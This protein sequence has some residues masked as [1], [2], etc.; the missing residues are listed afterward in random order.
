MLT[1]NGVS[2]DIFLK[3]NSVKMLPIVSAE[4]NQNI[5]NPVYFTVAG[6]G[7][8]ETISQNAGNTPTAVTDS[9]K[10]P[11]F[12]TYKFTLNSTYNYTQYNVDSTI[13]SKKAY[14]IVSYVTTDSNNPVMINTYAQ[15][16]K[17][18]QFGSNNIEVN[19]FGWTKVETYIGAVDNITSFTYKIIASTFS[20]DSGNPT[21]FYTK[22]EA[23]ETTSFDYQ[24][25][26][27]WSTDTVFAGFRPGESYVPTGNIF[28][29][30]GTNSAFP[31]DYRRVTSTDLLKSYSSPFKM[32]ISPISC[33]P[34]FFHTSSPIP[35]YKH[36][37][38]TDISQYRYFVSDSGSTNSITGFYADPIMINKLVLK[39]NTYLSVPTVSITIT[40]SDDSTLV[41]S[42]QTVD[43]NGMLILY[44]DGSTMSKNRWSNMPQIDESGNI[45]QYINVKKITVTQTAANVRSQFIDNTNPSLVDDASKMNLIEVSPR[46]EVDL[47]KYVLDLSVNKSLD[48]KDT[49][50]PI[51]SVVTD[52]ATITLSSLPLGDINSPIPIFSNVSNYS[53]TK[54]KGMLR[55]N[56]KFYINYDLVNFSDW[57]GLD[58]VEVNRIIPGGVFYSDTWQQSDI[59][60]ISVQCFD[61]T[62]YMQS[63]PV[64][65]YVSNK[66]DA[67]EVISNI[68]DLSGFT[69]YDIDSLYAVCNDNHTPLSLDYYF[70][71]SK[72]TTLLDALNQIFLPYQ[73]GAYIDNFGVM[74]FLSLSNI[75]KMTGSS[76][77]FDINEDSLIQGGY[78]ITSKS[79]PGKISLRYTTPKIKQSLSIQNVKDINIANGPSYI[80]TTSNDVVWSQQSIDSVGLNYMS[81]TMGAHDNYFN[82]N[83][84][85]LLDSFHTFNLS[86]NGYVVIE[87]EIVSFLYKEYIISKTSD[88]TVTITVSVKN[89]LE[90][91]SQVDKF[92]KRNEIGFGTTQSVGII[93]NATSSE[94]N[95]VKRTTYSYSTTPTSDVKLP[96]TSV[97]VGDLVSIEGMKPESLNL[98]AKVESVTSNSFTVISGQSVNMDGAWN[99]GRFTKG[100][101]YDVTITPTG[102]ITNV[103]RGMFGTNVAEH[104]V[105]KS[106][107]SND[108][109][110]NKDIKISKL[111]SYSNLITSQND[112][113]VIVETLN[114]SDTGN[115]DSYYRIDVTPDSTNKI[116]LYPNTEPENIYNTFSAKF[117]F[118]NRPDD[119]Q[120]NL[121]SV[122]LFFNMDKS[123]TGGTYFLE[124][125]RYDV[126]KTTTPDY[127]YALIFSQIQ[128][129]TVVPLAYTS[130]TGTVQTI[131]NS[132]EKLYQKNAN[133]VLADGT[134]IYKI[135]NDPHET[136]NLRFTK[137]NYTYTEDGEGSP[138][139]PTGQVFSVFLNNFE[140][141]GWQIFNGTDWIENEKNRKTGLSKKIKLPNDITHKTFGVFFSANPQTLSDNSDGTNPLSYPDINNFSNNLV[142]YAREIY[143]TEKVLKERSVSYYFQ[144]REFLNGLTQGQR[145]FSN[146]KEYIMQTEPTVVGINVYDVQYT[147]GAAVSVDVLPVEYAWIYY[148]GN[149]LADQRFI[150][151]QIVDEYSAAYSTPI[152][153]GFRA[154]FA[155]A[156]N[157]SH[158]VYLKKDS[159]DLNQFVVNLN[160]WTHEIIVP[161]DP[162]ILEFVTDP[163]NIMETVQIDSPLIQSKTA[164]T[165]L[166]KLVAASLDNFSKDISINIFGNPLIEVG[167]VIGLTYNLAGINQQKYVVHSVSHS[168]K[169]GLTTKLTLNMVNKGTNV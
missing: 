106:D 156:N 34:N 25:G 136:F 79:K 157:S 77:N 45:T 84:A 147:N 4:W 39:F 78:S 166:L 167:D 162:D 92:I 145:L 13:N 7:Q 146:Y 58:T 20:S 29:S 143:A 5:F 113:F 9:N 22:P 60:T 37:L 65:D 28:Y 161:S 24:Y 123:S 44:L 139:N 42:N 48:S 74:R 59:D 31:D 10:H 124:M 100:I 159:D 118:P 67:F 103:T 72:D 132:F 89:D 133:P 54:L 99:K 155:I 96:I 46:L 64:T 141:L 108:V 73:I 6:F 168:Y 160:L 97:K 51:S 152:N 11:N 1:V 105:I 85:D 68:L 137:Y 15:G 40:K 129:D 33:T 138:D 18:R 82:I 153:T 71:S 140:I 75:M 38:I 49:Y 93:S 88:P 122:G 154:K 32:P 121:C 115:V 57:V 41:V 134:D 70:S 56:V 165:G 43:D 8:Q 53:S 52:D 3:S 116:I 110:T 81:G 35:I 117:N 90:L 19:S 144:D 87:D 95:G 126:S 14:K 150:Q 130:I 125:V 135:Y 164:A 112:N 163:G 69:D 98:S 27:V 111:D 149:Q 102:K 104:S 151:H 30:L 63:T 148:P 21:I 119:E 128:N 50:M 101:D 86:T 158:M 83:S 36:G 23:Y 120:N 17:P 107:V 47:T 55:K 91:S 2:K 131:I 127:R 62:R 76:T 66:K 114:N 61:I 26:S 80:Y 169:D 16:T 109:I 142:G 12:D 94:T